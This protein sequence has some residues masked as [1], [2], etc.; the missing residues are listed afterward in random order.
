MRR[1]DFLKNSTLAAASFAILP[2]VRLFADSAETKVKIGL[3]GTGLRGQE[4]LDL[5]LRRDDVDL[6]AICDVD[7]R[8]LTMAKEI[9]NKSG[10]KMPQI[11]TG[12]K[13]A[14][15]SLL[16]TKNLDAVITATPWEWH[17]P[18]VMGALEAGLKYVAT[19]VILGITGTW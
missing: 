1:K 8:M 2:S 13:Y 6:V 18:V 14:W 7:D 4:H 16:E 11:F 19:E 12:D 15:K 3:I 9:I 5:L 10:K 17:K